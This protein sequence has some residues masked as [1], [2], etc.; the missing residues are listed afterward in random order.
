[1]DDS[2]IT[3]SPIIFS[4][5]QGTYVNQLTQAFGMI[6]HYAIQ[7]FYLLATIEIA[8]FGI[9]WALKQQEMLAA[10]LLKIVKLGFIFFII[11]HYQY[12]LSALVNGF[13]GIGIENSSPHIATYIFNPDKLWSFGFDSSISLLQLAVQYG[14]T[15]FGITSIYLILGFGILFMFA[16]IA[17]QVIILVLSFYILSLLALLLLPFGSFSMT[18]NLSYQALRG[19]LQAGAR[20]FALILVLGIGIGIWSSMHIGAFSQT[21]TLDKPLGLFFSTLLITLLSFFMPMYAGRM[22]GS[23]GNSM[24]L[25]QGGD[26]HIQVNTSNSMAYAPTPNLVATAAASNL[27]AGMNTATSVA[28]SMHS[29]SPA[30]ASAA[31]GN[32][33]LNSGSGINRLNQSMGELTKAV[34]VQKEAGISRETL[35]KLKHTFKPALNENKK[36]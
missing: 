10:F 26:A 24:W 25:P 36:S 8:F 21:S 35:N 6:D 15:N 7:L 12:I 5:I 31:T 33:S 18:Q 23:F 20:I 28:A 34:N 9:L 13:A 32:I 1:M 17:S 29:M 14:T 30:S 4:S 16:L 2:S 11:S 19:I 3:L 22:I 27:S